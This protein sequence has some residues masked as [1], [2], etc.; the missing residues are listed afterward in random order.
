MK[1][2]NKFSL[3]TEFFKYH[4]WK[5]DMYCVPIWDLNSDFTE[6]YAFSLNHY[7]WWGLGKMY[8]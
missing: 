7:F 5:V 1:Q 3:K 8:I 2:Q 6:I 4:K